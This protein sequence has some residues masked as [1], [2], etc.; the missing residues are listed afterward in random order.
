MLCFF[1][2]SK[3]NLH[4]PHCH[5]YKYL[6]LITNLIFLVQCSNL[7]RLINEKFSEM[8]SYPN[9]IRGKKYSERGERGKKIKW[10]NE[11]RKEKKKNPTLGNNGAIIIKENTFIAPLVFFI[12][13]KNS[14]HINVPFSHCKVWQFFYATNFFFIFC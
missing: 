12:A 9:A 13:A 3:H 2:I 5:N 14:S 6:H 11:K 7:N 4:I 8:L 10:T 1:F